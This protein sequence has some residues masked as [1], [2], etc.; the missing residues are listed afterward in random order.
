MTTAFLDNTNRRM[1]G[2]RG[3]LL[4]V[5]AFVVTSVVAHFVAPGTTDASLPDIGKWLGISAVAVWVLTVVAGALLGLTRPA[6]IAS[7]ALAFSALVL[8]IGG[9]CGAFLPPPVGPIARLIVV[10]VGIIIAYARVSAHVVAGP[11]HP[12]YLD[13]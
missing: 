10:P 11:Y 5:L 9:F 2:L 12:S 1:I 6:V 13:E 8:L 4:G 3:A 7:A